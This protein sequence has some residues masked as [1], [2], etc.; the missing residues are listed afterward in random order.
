MQLA[1]DQPLF[2]HDFINLYRITAIFATDTAANAHLETHAG[3]GVLATWDP[4][5]LIAA[6]TNLGTP[7]ALPSPDGSA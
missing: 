4:Y 2:F 3:E 5:V 6:K 7:F 1:Q